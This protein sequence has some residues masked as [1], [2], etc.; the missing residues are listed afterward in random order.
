M[1]KVQQKPEKHVFKSFEI[2]ELHGFI[3]DNHKEGNEYDFLIGYNPI[4]INDFLKLFL[5]DEETT[6]K[7]YLQL[8]EILKTT[9]TIH[10]FG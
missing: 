4:S 8:Y 2:K 9:E 10:Y 7:E 1:F 3:I 5:C 6:Y